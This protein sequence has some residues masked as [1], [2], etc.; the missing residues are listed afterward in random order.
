MKQQYVVTRTILQTGIPTLLASR[1]T[2]TH[3]LKM[4]CP[5]KEVL[6]YIFVKT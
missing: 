5:Q 2:N 6:P 4:L 3:I 1:V